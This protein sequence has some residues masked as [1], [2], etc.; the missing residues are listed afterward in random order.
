MTEHPQREHD[1][2]QKPLGKFDVLA[3]LVILIPAYF[4]VV[5]IDQYAINV[6]YWDIW[7]WSVRR[8]AFDVG[9]N[10]RDLWGLTNE[11][12]M[13]FPQI[14]DLMIANA[15]SLDMIPR[16]YAKVPLAVAIAISLYFLYRMKA[17]SPLVY[18][19]V[20][21]ISLFTF[22]LAYWPAWV[23][24]NPLASHLSMLTFILAL[25]AIT[26]LE[27][28]WRALGLAAAA[29]L[30]S[31][32]SYASG[33]ASWLVICGVMYLR[34]YRKRQY[35]TAWILLAFSVLIPYVIDLYQSTT[36]IRTV[37]PAGLMDLGLFIL[38]FLGTPVSAIDPLIGFPAGI[39]GV[40]GLL[41]ALV[42]SC[43]IKVHVK[44]GVIKMMPW[45]ALI[46]WTLVNAGA[47]ALGRSGK[48]GTEGAAVWRYAHIQSLFWIGIAALIAILLTEPRPSL[49]HDGQI[50][51]IRWMEIVAIILTL[52]IG[53]G[54]I[55][56]NL[57]KIQNNRIEENADHF[58]VAR[59]CLL[60]Y[61]FA[62]DICLRQLYPDPDRIRRYM[63]RLIER[64]ASFLYDPGLKFATALIEAENPV[65]VLQDQIIVSG[66]SNRVIFQHPP[67]ELTW[68]LNLQQKFNQITLR[69]GMIVLVPPRFDAAP[70]DGVLFRISVITDGQVDELLE[71][72]V[73]PRK[74][75]EGFQRVDV[76]LSN[77]AGEHIELRLSTSP[78]P[79]SSYHANY[80]LAYWLYPELEFK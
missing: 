33:N 20:V 44:E 71:E 66:Q 67:S 27:V 3:V 17:T 41:G 56:A 48:Y 22:S 36:V 53:I 80:D 61:E 60:R 74:E 37:R 24:P 76:D 46:V 49:Q 34:G 23:D 25:W 47:A 64:G 7:D 19:I 63:P 4:I 38:T 1:P 77:Y 70:S 10:L 45:L 72:M 40:L 30:V 54:Y 59:E 52:V 79:D 75:G 31:S 57:H 50:N 43:G 29:T 5:L 14:I 69:T 16:I 28:G 78:G 12:R 32:L 8:F 39:M 68:R 15:T 9:F 26:G 55:N 73:L 51:K 62:D 42:L 58:A 11:H 21:P 65:W 2:H 18:G 13:V 35:Y 6:P